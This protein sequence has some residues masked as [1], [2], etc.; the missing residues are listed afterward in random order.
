MD[1]Y[2]QDKVIGYWTITFQCRSAQTLPTGPPLRL[3]GW[4]CTVDDQEYEYADFHIL[5]AIGNNADICA[6]GLQLEMMQRSFGA[7]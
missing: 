4:S 3:R 5:N 2:G 1:A 7:I 6:D